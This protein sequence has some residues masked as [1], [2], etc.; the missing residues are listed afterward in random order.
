[1]VVAPGNG[2]FDDRTAYSVGS[3]TIGKPKVDD[4]IK[5]SVKLNGDVFTLGY[6]QLGLTSGA[7]PAA[8]CDSADE[9]G[10]MKVDSAVGRL[11]ICVDSGWISK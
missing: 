4:N 9:R 5:F 7:P 2:I 1:M 11:Y 8:D 6:V 10:R 3:Q